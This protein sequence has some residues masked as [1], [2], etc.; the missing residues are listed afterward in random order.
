MEKKVTL[1]E[2]F[3][4]E[5]FKKLI[6][7]APD[8][9]TGAQTI[10]NKALN[11]GKK[12]IDEVNKEKKENN[13]R[14]SD[15]LDE[16]L[17]NYLNNSKNAKK[18]INDKRSPVTKIFQDV[19]KLYIN[20]ENLLDVNKSDTFASS[21][22]TFRNELAGIK[23]AERKER[24]RKL[25]RE[26]KVEEEKVTVRTEIQK[27]IKEKYYKYIEI[28]KDKIFSLFIDL[29]LE[30]WNKQVEEL[31]DFDTKYPENHYTSIQTKVDYYY[32]SDEQYNAIRDTQ[33]A[34]DKY[35]DFSGH[36]TKNIDTVKVDLIE[37]L[38][39]KKKE[40]EAIN[41]ANAEEA[42][43]LKEKQAKREAEEAEKARLEQ[44][45]QK[46]NAVIE[47]ESEDAVTKANLL[48]DM[49]AK[50]AEITTENKVKKQYKIEITNPAGFLLIVSFYFQKEGNGKTVEV[51][52]KKSL[53]SMVT[54]AEKYYDKH[55]EKVYSPHVIYKEVVKALNK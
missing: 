12:L 43:K 8:I 25:Q 2:T 4:P 47:T 5:I 3:K 6:D 30:N 13:G 42:K 46:T 15:T 40:L 36:F 44:E 49:E 50:N 16:R 22:Q 1:P 54:F 14:I 55:G 38:P 28:V 33:F 48:F 41:A 53:N 32:I 35:A 45:A 10:V 24:E 11:I 21:I 51:L 34:F 31:K 29:T 7:Q 26:K 20:L 17:K 52:G 37:K 9:Y 39:G 18:N 19:S 23:E 27:Q